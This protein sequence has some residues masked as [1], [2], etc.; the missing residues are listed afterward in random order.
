MKIE[1]RLLVLIKNEYW[2][3]ASAMKDLINLQL[4]LRSL[5]SSNL[6][7]SLID[8]W[9]TGGCFYSHTAAADAQVIRSISINCWL[10]HTGS[11]RGVGMKQTTHGNVAR[12]MTPLEVT[13]AFGLRWTQQHPFLVHPTWLQASLWLDLNVTGFLFHL[14]FF[15]S[16]CFLEGLIVLSGH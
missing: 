11:R 5:I 14:F 1:S 16:F 4:T 2:P 12:M 10:P 13:K 15:C 7:S 8:V 9:M 6:S 3:P